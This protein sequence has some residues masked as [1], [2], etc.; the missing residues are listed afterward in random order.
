VRQRLAD[1]NLAFL[2][3]SL[4]SLA[5][6]YE[7]VHPGIGFGGIA[8]VISLLLG[9]FGLSVLPVNVVGVVLLVL[10]FGLFVAE[11]FVPGVGVL[12]A[13]GA[14]SLVMAGLFLVPGSLGVSPLVILP[15]AIV[16]GG[17]VVLGGRLA[18]RARHRP[19]RTGTSL[20]QGRTVT[21]RR[22]DG[23]KGQVFLDGTW[24]TVRSDAPL[25]EGT[26]VR[27]KAVDGLQLLVEPIPE[28]GEDT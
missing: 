26:D 9:M 4:G 11:M 1:P 6:F 16:E 21:V 12:A 18:W 15:T 28:G 13:G 20:L 14:V 10:S 3:L 22:A 25:T 8:G 23:P 17:L 24:W 27:V 7:L 2:F 5:I 19:L